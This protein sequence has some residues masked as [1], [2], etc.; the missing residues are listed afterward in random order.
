MIS[1]C[2][3]VYNVDVCALADELNK[4]LECNNI[5][6]EIIILDDGSN[7]EIRAINLQTASYS[8]VRYIEQDNLGRAKTRNRLAS[9]ANFNKLVFLDGDCMVDSD[10]IANYTAPNTCKIP[11]IIGG[12]AY[13]A[14]P[15]KKELWLRWNYGRKREATIKYNENALSFLSSNFMIDK[16]LFES[17]RFDEEVIGYGHE[18]TLFG[19]QLRRRSIPFHQINNPVIHLG[20]EPC[21]QF[22]SKTKESINNLWLIYKRTQ[23]VELENNRMIKLLKSNI[24]QFV[25]K[26]ISSLYNLSEATITRI[27]S[28]IYPSIFIFDLYKMLYIFHLK[29]TLA[30]KNTHK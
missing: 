13:E 30:S 10:F 6:G 27:L 4:Q 23:V 15:E 18:D 5:K 3:P 17:I 9:L 2:I 1:I 7:N 26:F 19:I 11:L 25:T 22:L 21:H 20:L 8:N 12:L 28:E 14:K 16:A 24:P 29:Y